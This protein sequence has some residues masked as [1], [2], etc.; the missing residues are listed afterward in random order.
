MESSVWI[1][2]LGMQMKIIF[3]NP[4]KVRRPIADRS[5][6]ARRLEL[7]NCERERDDIE[8]AEAMLAWHDIS[9]PVGDVIHW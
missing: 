1:S 8:I 5:E 2:K 9:D 6:V 4:N 7:I 3:R